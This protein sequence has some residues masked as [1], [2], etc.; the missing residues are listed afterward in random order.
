MLGKGQCKICDKKIMTWNFPIKPLLSKITQITP[1]LIKP[2]L[3]KI[4]QI[5]PSLIKPLLSKITSFTGQ[6]LWTVSE[7]FYFISFN[8]GYL[9]CLL[10]HLSLQKNCTANLHFDHTL[11]RL[12]F[13]LILT[14]YYESE[15]RVFWDWY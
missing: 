1:S 2:L 7:M 3:S 8:K 13:S 5:T 6:Y 12:G 4:T 11:D 15:I 10:V 9:S 14:A